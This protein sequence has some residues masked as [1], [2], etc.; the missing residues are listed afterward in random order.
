MAFENV[1]RVW[2]INSFAEYLTTLE[3]PMWCRAVVL[4]HTGAPCL[5]DRPKGLLIQ[6]M[7]NLQYF[8][9]QEKGWSAGPHLFVDEDELFG[10]CDLTKKGIHAVSFNSLAIGIE[11]LGNYDAEDP[12]TGRGLQ[13]W[14]MAAAAVKALLDW[15]G[16]PATEQTILF[17]RDDP[18]TG[19]KCPGSKVLKP[20]IIDLVTNSIGLSA[21]TDLAQQP[22]VG[23]AWALWDFRGEKW[24]VPVYDFLVAKGVKPVT[25]A[26][27][28]KVVAG[29]YFYGSELLEGAYY[30]KA[31]DVIKPDQRTWAPA[32]EVMQLLP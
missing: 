1:G 27:K 3:R 21:V 26:K 5:A 6:H 12:L 19:K 29:E 14:T 24:C 18:T 8:Y 28:L 13:C 20:W 17:H 22:D 23:M 30:V 15:L 31:N 2:T 32:Y 25:I 11:V 9:Q 16:L 10:M 7:H 4:H